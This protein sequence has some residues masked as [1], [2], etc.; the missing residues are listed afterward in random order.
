MTTVLILN[1]RLTRQL[2]QDAEAFMTTT[3]KVESAQ[4]SIHM[5]NYEPWLQEL[6]LYRKASPELRTLG[7]NEPGFRQHAWLKP[8]GGVCGSIVVGLNRAR[9]EELK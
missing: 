8:C 4:E 2:A 6:D 1:T 7:A 3:W 9:N 5:L